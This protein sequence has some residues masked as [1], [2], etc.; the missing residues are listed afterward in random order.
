MGLWGVK[1]AST[2]SLVIVAAALAA[3]MVLTLLRAM[4]RPAPTDAGI[5][6]RSV[7]G[8]EINRSAVG[9]MA[10]RPGSP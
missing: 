9:L 3:V 5:T 4:P 1:Q 8:F 7:A 2:L 10:W 6:G